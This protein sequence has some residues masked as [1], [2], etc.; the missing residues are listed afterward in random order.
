MNEAQRFA[1]AGGLPREPAVETENVFR[2][3]KCR[4]TERGKPSACTRCLL[5]VDFRNF[6]G[7]AFENNS[8]EP[9]KLAGEKLTT[10]TTRQETTK[11]SYQIL[12]LFWQKKT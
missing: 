1:L 7:T 4:E 5:A 9:T 10:K 12:Q 8:R 6:C 3:K 2:A 11:S